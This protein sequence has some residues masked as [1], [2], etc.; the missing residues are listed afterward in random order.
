[1]PYNK[2]N[3]INFMSKKLNG[4][5]T[6]EWD[7]LLGNWDLFTTTRPLK[8]DTVKYQDIQR[9]DIM[10]SRIYG[11]SNYWW[12]LCKFNQIDDVWNDLYVGMDLLIP[13]SNDILDFYSN[14]RRR[15]RK[16]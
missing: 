2:F 11:T 5:N 1:M 13:D 14:V 8:F 10:S 9:P 3:R 16:L 6:E 4:V 15:V 7:M 12:I